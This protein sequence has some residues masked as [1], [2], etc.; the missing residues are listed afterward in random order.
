MTNG[1][2]NGDRLRAVWAQ[3]SDMSTPRTSVTS[4]SEDTL[5]YLDTHQH[6]L[7]GGFKRPMPP[8]SSRA[9]A[10]ALRRSVR[11]RQPPSLCFLLACNPTCSSCLGRKLRS[12][13]P[14]V[15]RWKE[16]RRQKPL[17]G[18]EQG[19][20]KGH[21]DACSTPRRTVWGP[22]FWRPRCAEREGFHEEGSCGYPYNPLNLD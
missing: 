20:S 17:W 14:R 21:A 11:P 5:R 3:G 4:L 9:R 6:L 2:L 8:N 15:A 7:P 19:Q 22:G 16:R 18:P 1:R 13:P 12:A 10:A